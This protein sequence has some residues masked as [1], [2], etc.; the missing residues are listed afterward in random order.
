MAMQTMPMRRE[1]R[2]P[3]RMRL[4]MSRPNSSVPSGFDSEGGA[5]R[6]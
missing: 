6:W 4:K 2:A 5:S 1:M 3:K